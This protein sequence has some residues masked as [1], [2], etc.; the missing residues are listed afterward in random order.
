MRRLTKQQGFTLIELLIV[1]VIIGILAT[2]AVKVFWSAK[3]RG[4]EA[5]LQSDLKTAAIHQENFYERYFTYTLVEDS[6]TE[7]GTSPGVDL[8]ITYAASDGWAAIVSSPSLISRRCG[9][10]IGAAPAGSAGPAT[11]PG[12][13][14]C[15]T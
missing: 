12:R 9:L 5:T 4:L 2:I 6:L 15:G 13:V 3:D 1:I 14:Q 11:I 10:L 7:F 8:D